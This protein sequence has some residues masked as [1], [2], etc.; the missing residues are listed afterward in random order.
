MPPFA[1]IQLAPLGSLFLTRPILRD[2]V[3]TREELLERANA[4]FGAVSDEK[5]TVRIEARYPLEEA[6][7][8]HKALDGRRTTG[9][10]LLV[11]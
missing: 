8:A 1:P 3:A 6:P 9:K 4:V 2:Y 10:L 7:S 11:P 5:L